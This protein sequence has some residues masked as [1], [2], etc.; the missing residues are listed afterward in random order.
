MSDEKKKLG[1]DFEEMVARIEERLSPTGAIVT[2]P[3]YIVDK[4]TG[5]PREVDASIRYKVG[6]SQILITI[7]CRDRASK[8]DATWL[9]Q[10]KSKKDSIGANQTIV[11]SREGFYEPAKTYAKQHGIELRE[12]NEVNDE[13]INNCLK[14][15]KV[16]IW[17]TKYRIEAYS[18]A[19]YPENGDPQTINL[20][21]EETE[22]I[23]R[24]KPFGIHQSGEPIRV[25]QM[26]DDYMNRN[27]EKLA[28]KLTDAPEERVEIRVMFPK[29]EIKVKTVLGARSLQ[30]IRLRL[31]FVRE[32]KEI[33][34]LKP[35]EYIG[36]NGEI[37][38]SFSEVRIPEW[39]STFSIDF[40]WDETK[41]SAPKPQGYEQE[42]LLY[43]EPN[44]DNKKFKWV[45]P[46]PADKS[47]K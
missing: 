25:S 12:I 43:P 29:N 46:D 26:V 37:H 9:E 1:R 28:A 3:D 13:F 16:T 21:Y 40:D 33:P 5:Q 17:M 34:T 32:E 24:N 19:V 6:S 4:V 45:K 18:T 36:V 27:R 23:K 7:E 39:G 22:K 2:S 42:Y 15:T 35:M 31:H 38:S 44:T 30:G 10:I 14:N 11:V 20:D 41:N 8:Q 47:N